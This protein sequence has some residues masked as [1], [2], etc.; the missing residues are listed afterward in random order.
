M[1][2]RPLRSGKS[3][4]KADPPPVRDFLPKT[5]LEQYA[6]AWLL[7]CE[8]RKHSARTVE[9]RRGICDRLIWFMAQNK[10]EN[11]DRDTLRR[12]LLY[13]GQACP[14]GRWGN[15]LAKAEAK[16]GTVET[17]HTELR[18]FFRWIVMECG[19]DVSPMENIQPPE[20]NPDQIIPFTP[21]QIEDLLAAAKKSSHPW[22][23]YAFVL[24]LLDTGARISELCELTLDRVNLINRTAVVDGKG[25]KERKIKFGSEVAR[26]IYTYLRHDPHEENDP[27]FKAYKGRRSTEFLTRSGGFQILQ[28]LGVVAGITDVRVSPHTC[29]H[30]FAI[31]YLREGGDQFS[32]MDILGHTNV[33]MTS[34]Y[35]H[36][37]Q[38]D[39]E[40]KHA[41]H[42][43]IDNMIRKK[44][45]P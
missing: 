14:T 12:F 44:R 1:I 26:A 24:M 2:R 8:M 5:K 25:N 29:R 39:V 21:K 45:K 11:C 32:L 42:S 19:L 4:A 9:N 15:P 17:Y 34:R 35:V 41:K 22:R 40:A 23:N 13:A 10:I 28:K 6:K 33:E 37:A 36:I 30:T 18:T 16:A 20:N 3:A 27:L 7:D 31:M 38:A 43:P